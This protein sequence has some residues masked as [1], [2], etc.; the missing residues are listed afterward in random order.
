MGIAGFVLS[1]VGIVLSF[2]SG[3]FSIVAL[4]IS[5]TG[6][7]LSV[8]AGKKNKTG[9]TTAGLVLGIIAVA[10]S[11]VLFFSC[12]LCVLCVAAA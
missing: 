12:G 9:L 10:L 3:F 1:I 6:L 4:P 7:V 2:F 5:I 8:V 11:A